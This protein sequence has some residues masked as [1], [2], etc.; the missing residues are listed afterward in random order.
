MSDQVN[1]E[2]KHSSSKR[3]ESPHSALEWG[4]AMDKRPAPV[5]FATL[6]GLALFF[7]LNYPSIKML[8]LVSAILGIYAI[9]ITVWRAALMIVDAIRRT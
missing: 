8:F 5:F 2:Q 4:V 7:G 1:S 6:S 9:Q 3:V